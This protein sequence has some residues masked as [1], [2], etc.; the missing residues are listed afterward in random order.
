MKIEKHEK[1]I[2]ALVI[3]LC[4]LLMIVTIIIYK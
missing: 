3:I 1:S 4:W 2:W